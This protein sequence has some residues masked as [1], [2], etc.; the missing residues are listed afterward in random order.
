MSAASCFLELGPTT[1]VLPS[2]NNAIIYDAKLRDESTEV[3][4]L[5]SLEMPLD[6]S[7]G[8]LC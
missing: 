5:G 7:R 3:G 1:Y 8:V 6:A 2:L 4:V